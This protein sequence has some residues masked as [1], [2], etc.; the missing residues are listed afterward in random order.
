MRES[1]GSVLVRGRGE[2]EGVIEE[3]IG[4]DVSEAGVAEDSD[5]VRDT[6]ANLPF[7]ASGTTGWF[8]Q[9]R[10][11]GSVRVQALSFVFRV[12][13]WLRLRKA[14]YDLVG[15]WLGR[16][17]FR[18]V[19]VEVQDQLA[20]VVEADAMALDRQ[21]SIRGGGDDRSCL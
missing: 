19:Q 11:T 14:A 12:S 2:V 4:G 13:V 5:Q 18:F 20:T 21:G 7:P 16:D 1:E 10:W 9:A 15:H 8:G 6:A 17:L 3:D